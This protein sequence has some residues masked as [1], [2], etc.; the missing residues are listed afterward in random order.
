MFM[1]DKAGRGFGEFSQIW[2]KRILWSRILFVSLGYSVGTVF[3]Y[4]PIAICMV[5]A[6][7]RNLLM[8]MAL[9]MLLRNPPITGT[10]KKASLEY[11]YF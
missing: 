10:T 5:W 8:M 1:E 3:P 9:V 2:K 11:R 7:S 4:S 6:M